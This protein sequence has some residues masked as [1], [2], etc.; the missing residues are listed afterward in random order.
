MKF[1]L[2]IILINILILSSCS[3]GSLQTS[4]NKLER[5]DKKPQTDLEKQSYSLGQNMG[6]TLKSAEIEFDP[7]FFNAGFYDAVDD[8]QMMT[9]EEIQEALIALQKATQTKQKEKYDLLSKNNLEQSQKDLKNNATIE[10][11]LVTDSGLQ[12]KILIDG[13]GDKPN[14][15]DTV[16]VHYEG[17]LFDGK[18][19]DSSIA[20]GEP[21]TFPVN[22]VIPGWTEALQMMS[23]GSKWQIFIPPNLG[24]GETGAGNIIGPNNALVFDVELLAIISEEGVDEENSNGHHS[25]SH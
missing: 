11:V 14:I 8:K 13:S 2:P 10:G 5:A 1:L 18:V 4:E 23:V 15:T 21:V 12:Y 24:Y 9:Q 25:H 20:R 6:I 22:G 16:K 17:R 3:D 19:F 7:A